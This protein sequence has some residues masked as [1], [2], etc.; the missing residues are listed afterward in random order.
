MKFSKKWAALFLSAALLLSAAG[1]GKTAQ[2]SSEPEVEEPEVSSLEPIVKPVL[3]VGTLK[4]PTGFGMLQLMD[5]ADADAA[6]NTYEFSVVGNPNELVT[7]MTTGELDAAAIP[8][9]LAATLYNKTQ[10]QV[11]LA[12][13]NTLGVL[14]LVTD[15]TVVE[16]VSS[17]QGQ[18]VYSSGQGAVPEYA[19]NY[20]LS[21]HG[22]AKSVQTEYLSEHAELASRLIAGKISMAVL[23][24]PFV[25]QVAQKKPSL[26]VA[27]DLTKE[28]DKATELLGGGDSVL[29]MGAL[30]V[31]K[32]FAE[33]NAEAFDHFLAEYKASV[34]YVTENPKEASLLSETYDIMP[35]AVAE[36]AIPNCNIVF[37]EG[38]DMKS[39]T[40]DFLQVLFDSNPQ[41][42]GGELPQ[43]DF[44]YT[45]AK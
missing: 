28:W 17:L 26:T 44:Y 19:W 43:D 6:D 39:K 36:K 27:L 16:D 38:D 42:V 21:A 35:A 32:E 37:L 5:R 4:G 1:C 30:V 14:Y 25:T 23:P 8:S 10:G 15:G 34:Q 22:L 41:A 2:P 11:Q 3:R 20:I 29:T 40:S 18:T 13:I 7:K 24:E 33:E 12:A 31:R 45:Y 9:N